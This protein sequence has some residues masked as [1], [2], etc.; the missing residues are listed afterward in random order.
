MAT[1]HCMVRP[2]L[3]MHIISLDL[4]VL[5]QQGVN[6]HGAWKRHIL[7]LK[8]VTFHKCLTLESGLEMCR[9]IYDI[10]A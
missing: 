3:S 6:L 5:I 2:S 10:V 7:G 1:V 4:H 9:P 8:C